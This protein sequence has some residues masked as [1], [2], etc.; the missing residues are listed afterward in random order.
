M[1]GI[2]QALVCNNLKKRT[3]KEKKIKDPA[4]S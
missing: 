2:F 1:K 3:Q 4:L